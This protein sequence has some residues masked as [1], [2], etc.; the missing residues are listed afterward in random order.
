MH[1]LEVVFRVDASSEIGTGHVMRCLTLAD[2]LSNLAASCRFICRSHKGHLIEM[3][4]ERGYSVV[5]LSESSYNS[6]LADSAPF[7]ARWLGTNI[8]RDAEE[9]ISALGPSSPDWIVVDHYGIDKRWELLMRERCSNI[10]VIDDLADRQHEC[11]LLLDHGLDRNDEDY[12]DLAPDHARVLYGPSFALLRPEFAKNRDASLARRR[13]PELRRI[14]ISMGGIDKDNITSVVLTA[15]NES[16]L[17]LDV[18]L[19]VVMGRNAPWLNE[20]RALAAKIDRSV[21]VHVGTTQMAEHMRDADLAI[22]AAGTTCWEICCLGLP[23]VVTVLAPNQLG[24]AETLES[25][26]VAWMAPDPTRLEEFLTVH[27]EELSNPIALHE[28]SNNAAQ[29]TDG[30]GANL[31]AAQ[32]VNWDIRPALA[33]Q[34]A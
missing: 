24:V 32:L 13:T 3:I 28:M 2:A 10:L 8:L 18:E 22:G 25:A 12:H 19:T 15:L 4:E 21:N 34:Y 26:G 6:E 5:A 23:S 17:P 31:V 7:H 27:L 16:A 29:I 30:R 33:D 11:D 9:T 1:K 20:V 14:L